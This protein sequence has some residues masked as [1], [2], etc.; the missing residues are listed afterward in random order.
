MKARPTKKSGV[1]TLELDRRDEPLMEAATRTAGKPSLKVKRILV[2]IDFS[3][4][5][6]K[7]LQYALPLA[8]EHRAALT[9]LY[10][11]SPAY[12]GA[13]FGALN[14]VELEATMQASGETQ[15][16]KLVAAEGRSGVVMDTLV[17][18]GSP[19]LEILAVAKSLPADLIVIST[20]GRTG[21]KHVFLG[22][23][24]EQVV[25]RAPCPVFVVRECE[26]EILA[27]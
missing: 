13:E 25:Q 5:S 17:R 2:P 1:V 19:A 3:D 6:K 22:S 14:Y 21:L 16:A 11:V 27:S 23:V 15:L 12:G 26:H 10:V 7:A 20:H 24:T 8:R 4:C 18:V 9:L